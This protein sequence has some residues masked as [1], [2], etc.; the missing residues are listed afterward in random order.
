MDYA[1]LAKRGKFEFAIYVEYSFD[2]IEMNK[3]GNV[4]CRLCRIKLI[5]LQVKIFPLEEGGL[6]FSLRI[7]QLFSI[8]PFFFG[9]F[10]ISL[11]S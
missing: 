8:P 7:S 2:Y 6:F 10:T 11:L 1:N 9:N 4:L 5:E 3:N